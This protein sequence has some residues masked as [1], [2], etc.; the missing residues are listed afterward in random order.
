MLDHAMDAAL[1]RA[2]ER[3]A[4]PLF[5]YDLARIRRQAMN[6]LAALPPG[7]ALHY[8]F[9]A[10]PSLGI[11]R[12]LQ[13]AGLGADISSE[14]EL[15]T[16]LAAGF[17][18]ERLLFT[19]PAKS[20]PVLER[21]GAAR[22]AL[23]VIESLEEARRLND[24]ARRLG[25]RQDVLLRVHPP[26]EVLEEA[27]RDGI[28]VAE[29]SSKFGMDD[30]RLFEGVAGLGGLDDLHLRGLQCYVA[31]NVLQPGRLL[32]PANWLLG[33]LEALRRQ[34]HDH[35][36]CL[37]IGGGLG[38]PYAG[39]E[40]AFDLPGFSRGLR[41]LLADASMPVRLLLEVGRYLVAESGC[42]LTRV[43]DVRESRGRT[44]VIV[45][46][47]IHNLLRGYN[48]KANRLLR[49]MGGQGR[50]LQ[51]VSIAGCLPTPQDVLVEDLELPSPVPGDLL[52]LPNC[53]AYAYHHSLLQF[54]LHPAP[55]EVALDEQGG[56]LLRRRG[57]AEAVL[58]DQYHAR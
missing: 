1:V 8:A 32:R 30:A 3:F 2:A 37:D 44:W 19:G 14:G 47:G 10:N 26:A 5:T 25:Y 35:L 17:P 12:T 29:A 34:G 7:A 18:P 46:G 53:G 22:P 39:D 55:A 11:C 48:G 27:A 41:E 49:L 57:R 13:E 28:P 4:T 54:G 20:A 51:R 45:D 52:V 9:K 16:A 50:P 36:D 38:V 43:L 33:R 23:V 24:L 40:P 42:Y 6:L 58:E 15:V 21:L 56:W 31:S